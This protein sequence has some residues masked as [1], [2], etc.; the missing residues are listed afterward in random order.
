MR[1]C[2]IYTI[3]ALAGISSFLL[4]AV[5]VILAAVVLGA[6]L[7]RSDCQT[8]AEREALPATAILVGE[9]HY[10][11]R[12]DPDYFMKAQI[13]A[14]EFE[15]YRKGLGYI[16]L[17]EDKEKYVYWNFTLL[18]CDISGWWDPTDSHDRTYYNPKIGISTANG[19][20][21]KYEEG[22]LYFH[23]WSGY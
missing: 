11:T 5:A 18:G 10:G 16:P 14:E 15:L 22:Y 23:S 6:Y 9:L 3:V 19:A 1:K 7:F 17:P 8:W 13:R 4:M 2:V 20:V 12:V 21:M